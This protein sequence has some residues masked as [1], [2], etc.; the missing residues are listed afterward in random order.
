[1]TLKYLAYGS[2]MLNQRLLERVPSSLYIES[3]KLN[4]YQLDFSVKGID[5]SGKCNMRYTGRS[6]DHVHAAVYHMAKE[7]KVL[8]D[9]F[10][11]DSYAVEILTVEGRQTHEV[12]VYLGKPEYLDSTLKPF[13]WYRDIVLHGARSREYPETYLQTIAAVEAERDTDENRHQ[14]HQRIIRESLVGK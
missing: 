14:E 6:E 11:G 5:G 4:G 1:M 9:A 10:E 12:F 2:N 3:V 13:C 8:L 7:E